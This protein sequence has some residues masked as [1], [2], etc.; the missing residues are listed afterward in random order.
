[1]KN[2]NEII[3]DAS[4]SRGEKARQLYALNWTVA[5]IVEAVGLTANYVRRLINRP[6]DFALVRRFGVEIEAHGV[7]KKRLLNAL[8]KAGIKVDEGYRSDTYNS[9]KVTSDGSLRGEKTFELVSPVLEGE[10]GLQE[11]KVVS[12]VLVA[13]RAKINQSCGLH[14]HFDASN[15][16][17]QTWKNLYENYANLEPVIDSMMPRSRRYNTYCQSIAKTDLHTKL[18]ACDTV[19]EIS[20][21][22]YGRYYKVNAESYVK[23]NTVEFRQHSGTI[24]FAKIENWVRFL[25]GLV[26][27]SE[28]GLIAKP[29]FE[30]LKRFCQPAVVAYLYNRIQ[31]LAA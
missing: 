3:A 25:D 7:G 15:M 27:Q 22:Y 17:V 30:L 26:K 28:R 31:S 4:L 24:E 29:T 20:K 9:W 10:A 18:Q 21:L 1:M 16:T 5:Q 14:I 23:H 13:L 2:A 12:D 6:I 8:R 19:Q 11:L